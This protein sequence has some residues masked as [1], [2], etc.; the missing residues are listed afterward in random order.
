MNDLA[1]IGPILAAM[2]A[3]AT[4]L[5]FA[6]LGELVVEKSGVLNLGVEG[7]MLVGA[8]CGF[9][10]TVR[11]GSPITGFVVAALAGAA[12]ASLFAVLTLFLLANQVATG[13]ALTLFGVG[14]SALIGQGFVGIPL[15]GLPKLHIPGLTDLPVVGQAL[16]GQDIMVYLAVAAVPLVHLF[17]YRTRAGLVLRAVGENHTAA[18]ALGYKVL[19]IRFFAVL[20]GGA[21][22]GLGGAFLSMDYTP[23]WAENMTS[24]RGWIALALVVFATWKPVRAML[25]AWL[26]GGVTILQLH[27]Q[28]LGIDVP[29]QLLSM[30]PYLATVLVLVLISRDVARIRLNAPACLG[31]LFHPDA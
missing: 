15:E 13:L 27:V 25:G 4:P 3:A 12:T 21:M 5:L 14:L 17:L 10:V 9:A 11:T 28:G 7:M 30:L 18:H 16:F 24:G 31:K 26:F 20:F 19:R 22:A 8:V 2:F 1:L 29:S 6:A 23:M